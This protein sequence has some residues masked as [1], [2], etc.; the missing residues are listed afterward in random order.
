[1]RFRGNKYHAR[2]V[3]WN[4]VTYASKGEMLLAMEIAT[5]IRAGE[6][7]RVQRQVSI[8]LRVNGKL[9]CTHRPDF[10]VELAGGGIEVWEFKGLE[11]PDWKL[12]RKLFEANFP[13][14]PYRVRKSVRA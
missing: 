14:I 9:I 10:I 8:P 3:K 6:L 13:S 5:M 12:K 2:R 7:V 4:G 1:V 11:L